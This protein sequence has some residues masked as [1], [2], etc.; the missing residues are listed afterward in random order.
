M[1]KGTIKFFNQEKGYGF[2]IP[3]NGSE[4]MFF[5]VTALKGVDLDAK[6]CK[7]IFVE[8]EEGMGKKNNIEAIKVVLL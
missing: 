1:K 2:I 5:H 4:D 6:N 8:Y 7:G 3:E